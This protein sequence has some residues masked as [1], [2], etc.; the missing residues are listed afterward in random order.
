MRLTRYTDFALRVLLYLAAKPTETASISVIAKA[1]DISQSHLMKVVHDLGKSGYLASTRGR[2]GGVRLARPPEQINIGAVIREMEESF[3][4][5]DCE[6]CMIAP[7]C[8]LT[9]AMN[10]AVAAFLKVLDGYS[11]ADVLTK[12]S[13]L[14]QLLERPGAAI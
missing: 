12:P 2:F 3:D 9:A 1:Y 7:A 11:L 10:Q 6:T 5:A 13:A 14:A 8:G 4:L